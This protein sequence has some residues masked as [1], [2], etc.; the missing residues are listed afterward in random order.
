MQYEL[1][2]ELALVP[3]ECVLAEEA[4]KITDSE[5]DAPEVYEEVPEIIDDTFDFEIEKEEEGEQ[6]NGQGGECNCPLP[7]HTRKPSGCVLVED[8]QLQTWDGVI[9]VEVHTSKTHIFGAIF[10]REAE[11]DRNG[12]WMI[13]HRYSGKIHVWVRWVNSA[14]DV[15]TMNGNLDLWGYTFARR[16]YIGRYWGPNFNNIS[17]MFGHT[18]TI[19]SHEFR[20]WVASTV[21]N[22]VFEYKDFIS[23]ESIEGSLNGNL[24]LLIT[25]WGN[26]NT[27]AA[28]MLDKLGFWQS[29]ILN[30]QANVILHGMFS[31]TGHPGAPVAP[32]TAWLQIA[33]PDLALNLN[34]E[35][36]VNADDVRELAY[37]E[38]SHALHFRKAGSPYWL[39]NIEY[40]LRHSGYGNGNAA[41]A[42]RCSVIESWGFEVGMISTHLRYGPNNSNVGNPGTNTWRAILEADYAQVTTGITPHIPNGWLWDLQDNNPTNQGGEQENFTVFSSG[43]DM[44]R[45]FTHAQIFNTMDGSMNSIPQMKTALLPSLPSGVSVGAYNALSGAYGF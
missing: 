7:D 37:H 3:E 16:E 33:A 5:Y 41:G 15:K 45:G 44:V 1:L 8:N 21:N 35:T 12:C 36:Q 28:P 24:K 32:I 22:S 40:T 43:G 20:N 27:G 17:I 2:E 10:H 23:S 4:F 25:P 9:N 14:C 39:R 6:G 11:T 26:D 31:V 19:D 18:N 30:L 34:Q 13:N 42:G 38:L 29:L